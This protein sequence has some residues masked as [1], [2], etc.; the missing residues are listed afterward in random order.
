MEKI[1]N[2]ILPENYN[3]IYKREAA[4][5]IALT[6]DVAEKL[7]E[8]IDHVNKYDEEDL[9]W[10]QTQEGIIRKGVVYMKDNLVNSLYHL[11]LVYDEEKVKEILLEAYGEELDMIR[12][13]ATPQM[14]GAVGDGVT[15]DIEAIEKAIEFLGEGGILYFPK[16]K[17]LMSGREVFIN[18]PNI[19]FTG[20]GTIFC[21]YGFRP[22][23]SNFK[24]IG[25]H[26][27]STAYSSNSRA[28]QVD[29][30]GA[31][32]ESTY[33][34]G[35]TFKDCTFKNFFY[36]IA[37]IGGSYSYD[38]TEPEILPY[39]VRDVVIENCYSKTYE[40]KN[41]GHFQCIQVENIA[42]I[43]N[44]TYGGTS[45][46]SYN[47]IKGNGYIRVI[48]N[49]DNGNTYAGCEIENGSGNVVVSN[50]TFNSQIWID[51]SFNVVVN[52]NNT[53]NSIRVT[54][55]S[56]NGDSD[57]ILITNNNCKSIWCGQFG[58]YQ[59]GLIKSIKID[60]NMI[61]VSDANINALF[62]HGNA[63]LKA[64]ISN[65]F[66][67]GLTGNDIAVQ[68]NEQLVCYIHHN[69]GTGQE[70]LIAGSG[71]TVFAVD[72]YNMVSS[73]MRDSIPA[74]HLE[75]SFNGIKIEDSN[76]D[77]WRINVSTA[78]ELSTVKY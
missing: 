17:Y 49:Y 42:Y 30:S 52:G 19:T 2:Y 78:G 9:R 21:D 38:G 15:N 66:I 20:D 29:N 4:S 33:I 28:F 41:T 55:G 39:P 59:G 74:S 71:G 23:A 6:R 72:N 3:T 65:N 73:G 64:E 50:N 53:T 68:R 10:K 58:E 57:N 26:M 44:R 16:G 8:I 7:N 61:G 56:D 48:G 54:V 18:K 51:D 75:R 46:S 62:L 14:F 47:A 45:A 77:A 37:C 70:L 32:D 60:G 13:F 63:V 40:D 1:K 67:N 31:A 27:E 35:F 34:E 24:A 36:A 25:L 69:F 76:G 22:K 43:N 5:S 12:V 11:L